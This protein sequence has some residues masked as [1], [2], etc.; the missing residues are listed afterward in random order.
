MRPDGREGD[1]AHDRAARNIA[2]SAVRGSAATASSGAVTLIL[3]LSRAVLL[4]RLLPPA[5]FGLFALA[6]FFNSTVN[7]LRSMGLHSAFLHRQDRSDVATSTYFLIR[8]GLL[9]VSGSVLVILAPVIGRFYPTMPMLSTIIVVCAALSILQGLNAVQESILARDLRFPTIARNRVVAS[10]V[11]TVVAPLLA[12]QG[13]GVWSLLAEVGA[14]EV[15]RSVL[16]WGPGRPWRPRFGWDPSVARSFLRYGKRLWVSAN[17]DSL[18]HRFDDFW[19]GTMLGEVSLGFYSRAYEFGQ[20]VQRALGNPFSVVLPTFARLQGDRLR[21]SQFFFRTTSLLVRLVGVAGLTLV[22]LA[23]QAVRLALGE[24]WM[25]M[26][27][28]LQLMLVSSLTRLVAQ[29]A[30]ELCMATGKPDALVRARFIQLGFFVPAVIFSSSVAGVTGVA[31]AALAT[32][33]LGIVILFRQ[34]KHVVDFSTRRLF[35]W[36]IVA[37]ALA[38]LSVPLLSD[39]WMD[40]PWFALVAEVGFALTTYTVLLWAIERDQFIDGYRLVRRLLKSQDASSTSPAE[41]GTDRTR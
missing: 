1:G 4:A 13:F 28:P 35:F 8:M 22:V 38:A 33:L 26:V 14:G 30:N 12:W 7:Q 21:L 24:R 27:V 9:V 3:G 17:L 15:A 5:D 18:L 41:P 20:Y 32:T 2:A 16:L 39:L 37:V 19:I 25:P 10:A 31:A 36:P 6:V 23:P 11:T 29:V 40:P 34:V